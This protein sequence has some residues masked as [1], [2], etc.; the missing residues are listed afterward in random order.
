MLLF[1][2]ILFVLLLH[3]VSIGE[4]GKPRLAA[5]VQY[6]KVFTDM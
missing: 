1:L 2:S 6:N 4:L 3:Y 5:M